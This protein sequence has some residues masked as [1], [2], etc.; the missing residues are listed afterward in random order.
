[1]HTIWS[2][3]CLYLQ[4]DE[5]PEEILPE[6]FSCPKQDPLS[7]VLKTPSSSF[8]TDKLSD[9][10]TAHPPT[11]LSACM[12]NSDI[13][14]N[15][16]PANI[17]KN[18]SVPVNTSIEALNQQ[19]AVASHMSQAFRRRFSQKSKENGADNVQQKLPPDSFQPS[20]LPVSESSLKKK[21]T[22]EGTKSHPKRFPA[23]LSSEAASSEICPTIHASQD[24][25]TPSGATPATPSKTIEYTENKDGSL[26]SIDAMSTPA[27][28]ACTP[29]RLMSVTPALPPPKRHYMSPDD[30]PTSSPNKLVRRPPRSRSLKFDTPVKNED[31]GD[32]SIDDDVFDILP[33]NLLQSVCSFLCCAT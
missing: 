4:G 16:D 33:D 7:D 31:T 6:P 12:Q 1:M 13:P 5:I 8:S 21:S 32:L 29:S 28:L 11:I 20:A 15:A 23:E 17:E 10:C 2:K 3:R 27:K 25:F 26:K 19:P 22:L 18:L 9:A 24:C 14:D 30:N